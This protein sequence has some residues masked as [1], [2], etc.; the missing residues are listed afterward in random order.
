M[1]RI[2]EVI[3]LF[4]SALRG[5]ESDFT[6]VSIDRAIFLLAIPMIAEMVL[7]SLF[8]VADVFFVS[9]ISVNAVAT[10]GLTESVLMIIYSVAI[11]LSMATTA[12]VA[13]RVGEKR[14]KAASDAGFQSIFLAI[15][16]GALLG[17]VGF[18]FSGDILALM[19]GDPQLIEEGE[20]FTKIMLAG[21]LSIFLLFLNNAI[22]RGAGDAA[23][24]MRALWLANGL[25]LILDPLLIFGL[26]PIPAM[27]LEG[28]A[29][30]TTT[31]R[32][33][34][35]IYQVFQ[36]LNKRGVIQICWENVV[37]RVKTVLELIKISMAGIGQFLVETASWIFLVKV[38]ALFGAEALA[39]YTIAFRVIVFTIL[40][41]W[42]ISNAAA[43]LVGQNL[44]AG[45]PERAEKSVWKTA[46]YNMI[47]LGMVSVI[48]FLGADPIIGFFTQ[49]PSVKEVAISALKIICIGYVFFAYG[50]VITQAFNGAGDTKTPL[51]I[52]FG[53]FW[54]FQIPMAYYLSVV[55]DW[56]ATGVFVS[57]AISHSVHAVVAMIIFRRGKWKQSVV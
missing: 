4:M 34:G 54:L 30:A 41:S 19:G 3:S 42:G 26:G 17:I 28:A 46:F 45:E 22:F 16:L 14:N 57:I 51:W 6:G 8:A 31:G 13:R 20:N 1:S 36:L 25:N 49:Q 11:G 21:N 40:P 55:L 39:G 33:I 56:Q 48:F 37:I 50:M 24:A 52:N 43:T 15:I 32:T 2:R 47:F 44:G 38:M 35:V 18:I 12:I 23:I 7:E 10:V 29:I 9:K 27:G 5:S 53:V